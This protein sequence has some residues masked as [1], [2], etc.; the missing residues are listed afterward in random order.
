M[1]YRLYRDEEGN[2]AA[3]DGILRTPNRCAVAL[4]NTQTTGGQ[5]GSPVQITLGNGTWVRAVHVGGSPSLNYATVVTERVIDWIT[6]MQREPR[7]DMV[8]IHTDAMQIFVKSP[9]TNETTVLR[10]DAN[11]SDTIWEIKGKLQ[12]RRYAE[13]PRDQMRLIYAN[14]DLDDNHTFGCY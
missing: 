1:T 2:R 9:F 10:V 6:D 8:Q 12:E 13:I 4:Y 7:T 14:K 3:W 11:G 5:S